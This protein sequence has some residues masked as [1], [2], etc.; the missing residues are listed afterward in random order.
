MVKDLSTGVLDRSFEDVRPDGL[1][2]FCPPI[3]SVDSIVSYS[4][5]SSDK[6]LDKGCSEPITLA[7]KSE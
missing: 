3:S 6:V 2:E 5:V 7:A 1:A 4:S